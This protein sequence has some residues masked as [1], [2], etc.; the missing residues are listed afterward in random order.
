MTHVSCPSC[1]V[2]FKRALAA[3]L[4]ECPLCGSPLDHSD[5]AGPLLGLRLFDADLVDLQA[6]SHAPTSE[7]EAA[8]IPSGPTRDD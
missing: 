1:R 6:S 7:T 2:R 5:S 8:A 3:H 4:E